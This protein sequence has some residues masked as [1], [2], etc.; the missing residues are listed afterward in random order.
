MRA[1]SG[2]ALSELRVDGGMVHNELLMEFQ[3]DILGIPVIRPFVAE[4]TA[5]GAAY[6]A[7]SPRVSGIRS[8]T[9][10][11]TGWRIAVPT[12]DDRRSAS[13]AL[14]PVAASGRQNS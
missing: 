4:T 7:G 2:V 10:V 11:P 13:V 9:C 8:M 6:A 12:E 14:H 5:L 3:A 1:D